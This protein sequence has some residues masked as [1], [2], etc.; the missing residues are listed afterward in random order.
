MPRFL[1]PVI[2][3]VGVFKLAQTDMSSVAHLSLP[4]FPQVFLAGKS[5]HLIESIG[6]VG[7]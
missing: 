7:G 1:R 3:K 4:L 6:K 2:E 5:M